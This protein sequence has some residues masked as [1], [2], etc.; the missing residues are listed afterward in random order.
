VSVLRVS[1]STKPK[2]KG[3]RS[4]ALRLTGLSS[5][6]GGPVYS[7]QMHPRGGSRPTKPISTRAARPTPKSD[8]KKAA[9]RKSVSAT[10]LTTAT[11]TTTTTPATPTSTTTTGSTSSSTKPSSSSSTK[12]RSVKP[13]PATSRI[14]ARR[15]RPGAVS[16]KGTGVRPASSRR[17][18][19]H[20]PAGSSGRTK[21]TKASPA[22]SPKHG[23]SPA[24]SSPRASRVP[25]TVTASSRRK[26]LS[27][28][29]A[30][31]RSPR[32]VTSPRN[33]RNPK[34]AS[35]DGKQSSN[36]NR[37]TPTSSSAVSS[38]KLSGAVAVSDHKASSHATSSTT[39]RMRQQR[40]PRSVQTDSKSTKPVKKQPLSRLQARRATGL[41]KLALRLEHTLMVSGSSDGSRPSSARP[42]SS[43][44][45]PNSALG[46]GRLRPPT[47]ARRN[48][49]GSANSP[50][51]GSGAHTPPVTKS[52]SRLSVTSSSGT[53]HHRK[54]TRGELKDSP[55]LAKKRRLVLKEIVASERVYV[56]Q[57]QNLLEAYVT[58]MLEKGIVPKSMVPVVTATQHSITV[59]YNMHAGML[60]DMAAVESDAIAVILDYVEHMKVYFPYVQNLPHMQRNMDTSS[61]DMPSSLRK[62]LEKTSNNLMLQSIL[63]LLIA[64]VQRLPRYVLL[65]ER[66]EKC[67]IELDPSMVALRKL[68]SRMRVVA[69]RVDDCQKQSENSA[70]LFTLQ[71]T[72]RSCPED[73]RILHPQRVFVRDGLVF[74]VEEKKYQKFVKKTHK[75]SGSSSQRLHLFNDVLLLTDTKIRYAAHFDLL[76]V[77][78]QKR[79][80]VAIELRSGINGVKLECI[81]VLCNPKQRNTWFDA[82]RDSTFKRIDRM[83]QLLLRQQKHSVAT[84]EKQDH[85]FRVETFTKLAAQQPELQHVNLFMRVRPFINDVERDLGT[86]CLE[87]EDDVAVLTVEEDDPAPRTWQKVGVYD[88]IF[89]E[90]ATQADVFDRVGQETLGAVF[91]GYNAALFAYG[92]TGAGKTHTVVG[93]FEDPERIGLLPRMLHAIYDVLDYEYELFE[94]SSVGIS[95]LQVYNNEVQDLQ[96]EDTTKNLKVTV[97]K[98]GHTVAKGAI[99]TE[100]KSAAEAL[101]IAAEADQKRVVRSH[102]M[103]DLSSRSHA[104]FLVHLTTKRVDQQSTKKAVLYL[105]DLAGSENAKDTGASGDALIECRHINQSLTALGRVVTTLIDNK[106]RVKKQPVPFRETKLTHL[107]TDILSGDFVCSIIL[108]ASPSPANNQADLTAKTMAFGAGVKKLTVHAKQHVKEDAP[109]WLV[110]VWRTIT[111]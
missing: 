75:H 87:V 90:D 80:D 63:Q 23:A 85:A 67:T 25:R 106:S 24:V 17:G 58:P 43:R 46:S 20:G 51:S 110:G 107:L 76:H 47:S 38:P 49:S 9:L 96:A 10:N 3:T 54:V 11:T 32:S 8:G 16:P 91:S 31:V 13:R 68:L 15:A 28:R 98:D 27:T 18:A 35:G 6:C 50:R 33:S 102:K 55:E 88:A 66:L 71:R 62:F 41:K 65:L 48:R 60:Q 73:F 34:R 26:P 29:P 109:N 30:S 83:N 70:A 94:E 64:P 19:R 108:N 2:K 81:L 21:K 72:I 101:K 100:V 86:S 44:A 104:I 36:R 92:C 5:L 82:I 77:H 39:R 89:G 61:S 103:N 57:V 1:V 7:L 95:Y 99:V 111:S 74:T 12:Q 56:E 14:G 69:G 84:D 22:G 4:S 53:R 45:S 93:D 79:D 52:K 37:N 78:A 59:L 97:D 105:I 42:G 40:P